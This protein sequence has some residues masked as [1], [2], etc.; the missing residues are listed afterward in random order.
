[1]RHCCKFDAFDIWYL[2]DT[3][4]YTNR[5][6]FIGVCPICKKQVAELIQKNINTNSLITI[7]KVGE[8]A[9]K[10]TKEA[11]KDLV[12]SRNDTNKMKFIPKPYGWRYG[13]NKLKKDKSGKEILEQYSMDF[14][15][16]S[17]LVKKK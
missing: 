15:G 16:N 5:T 2:K 9:L 14:F 4:D 3:D 1:M 6:L 10:Y 12:S 7:K 17:E 8:T 11:R 13:V